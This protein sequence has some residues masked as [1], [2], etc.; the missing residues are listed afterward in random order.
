MSIRHECMVEEAL[1]T[2]WYCRLFTLRGWRHDDFLF[3][4]RVVPGMASSKMLTSDCD[5]GTDA[6]PRIETAGRLLP[7]AENMPVVTRNN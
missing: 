4:V 7:T 5:A 3:K 2:F 1:L 6:R